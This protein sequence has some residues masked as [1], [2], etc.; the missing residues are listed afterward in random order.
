MSIRRPSQSRADCAAELGRRL[1]FGGAGRVFRSGRDLHR[2]G[3]AVAARPRRGR[4]RAVPGG[5]RGDRRG[6]ARR[7]RRRRRADRE[8]DRGVGLGH[9]RH[10]RVRQRPLDPARDRPAGVA[11]P[12]RARRASR[13]TDVRT[14]RV[15]PARDRAVPGLAREEAARGRDAGVALDLRRGARGVEVEAHRHGRDLQRARGRDLRARTCSPARSRTIP[16]TRPASCSSAG[17]FPR[18]PVTTRRRSCAS[19]A[20]TSRVRCCRS[21]RSSRPA[22]INLT[23]LE[24]RPTKR[25]LGDYCFFIDCEGHIADEVLADAL[26]NLVAKQAEVKFLG[27]YPVAGPVE[28]GVARRKAAGRAWKSAAGVGRDAARADPGATGE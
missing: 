27:S 14:R 13:S 26:R 20:R 28:A 11:Q 8:H 2:R 25:G 15:V 4:A 12:V 21:C 3:A 16:R 5:P 6:R 18:R 10:A 7:R 17:A 9:A 24:S 19:S 1:A 22:A 23:K